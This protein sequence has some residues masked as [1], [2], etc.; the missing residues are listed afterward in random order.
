MMFTITK[1]GG[2]KSHIS[3]LYRIGIKGKV[4]CCVPGGSFILNM[5]QRVLIL[6][7][8]FINLKCFLHR[9]CESVPA[10]SSFLAEGWIVYRQSSDLYHSTKPSPPG[11]SFS[12]GQGKLGETEECVHRVDLPSC[13]TVRMARTSLL[14][15]ALHKIAFGGNASL[16][17]GCK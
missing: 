13:K 6:G 3:K 16:Q 15:N 9:A 1:K 4:N 17:S 10:F 7:Y 5:H 14:F 12:K 8:I 2:I 11:E